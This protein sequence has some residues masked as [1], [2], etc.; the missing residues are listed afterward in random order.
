V[1]HSAARSAVRLVPGAST[2]PAIAGEGAR[3][4]ARLDVPVL[5][6]GGT[7]VTRRKMAQAIHDR[8]PRWQGPFVAE[9]AAQGADALP[10][11]FDQGR[12]GTVFLDD[13][14]ALDAA[15]QQRLLDVLRLAGTGAVRLLTG[16]ASDLLG[17]VRAGRFSDRLFY[18]LNVLR[19]D[20]TPPNREESMT[21]RD[22]MSTPPQACQPTTDLAAIAHLMWDYDCGF[23]PVVEA[24]GRLAGVITDRDICIAAATRRHLP[25]RIAAS[26]AMSTSVHACLPDDDVTSVLSAMGRYQV[27]RLP[28]V[29]THGRLQG[30][31]SMN[32]VVRAVGK[33]GAPTATAV[34]DALAGI[35]APR[36]VA[37]VA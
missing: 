32:D 8:S 10:K 21:A 24:D 18:E 35:C 13:V 20:V 27:R 9:S 5:I 37:A 26:Q 30:V 17:D 6:V 19:V 14:G 23:V 34:V 4:A 12:G 16:A 15:L 3:V 25:E 1:E 2:A 36:A 31:V 11:W 29:D 28:V 7:P 33:A 22:L